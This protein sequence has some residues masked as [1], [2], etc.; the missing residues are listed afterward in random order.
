MSKKKLIKI[1]IIAAAVL[2]FTALILTGLRLLVNKSNE[3]KKLYEV[4]VETY[5]NVIEVSGTVAAAQEQT[6]Q[7]LSDGTVIAVYVS[8]GDYVKKGSLILQL[9]DTSEQYNLAKHDYE[10]ATTQI[11][12]SQKELKLMEAQRLSLLQKIADRKVC[13]TFDGVIADLDVAVGDSL[14]AKDSVGTLVNIDYLT[15]EVEI[16]ETD[17]AK[18]QLNQKVELNF[19]AYKTPVYG[20][21]ES[22][23]AIGE[24]TSRGATIVNA[25]IR[26]DDYPSVILPNFSFT[27]KIQ[28][29][30]PVD[31][32]IVE[33]YAIGYED[34]E[35]YVVLAKS[36]EKRA[37]KVKPYGKEYVKVLEGLTGG[38][39][40]LQQTAE[41]KSGQNKNSS[42]KKQGNLPAAGNTGAAGFKR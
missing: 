5:E 18:L 42:N 14:E 3:E 21:I 1:I 7:A 24:I 25:K 22:W 34:K 15:A 29:E 30:E 20:Y 38:E 13:A 2:L 4:K 40:L 32:I 8:A 33:R 12:G 19:S 28:I 17:V 16:P 35:P 26:I 37:V 31:N 27:G 36:G 23:P 6:L 9:D 11:S 41:K 10:M 39:L